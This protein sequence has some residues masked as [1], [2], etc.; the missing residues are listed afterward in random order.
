MDKKEKR[1]K[2]RKRKV[3]KDIMKMK[4]LIFNKIHKKKK[5]RESNI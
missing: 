2:E 4:I 1:K 5:M 3:K